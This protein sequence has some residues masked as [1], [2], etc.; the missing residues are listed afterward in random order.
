MFL[1]MSKQIRFFFLKK[2]QNLRQKITLA[3]KNHEH[4]LMVEI[5]WSRESQPK[6]KCNTNHY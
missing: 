2:K 4:K 6:L 3:S 5:T 1:K